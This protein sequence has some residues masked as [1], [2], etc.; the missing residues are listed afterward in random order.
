MPTPLDWWGALHNDK[1]V[2]VSSSPSIVSAV[3]AKQDRLN[4]RSSNI[5]SMK[6]PVA[7]QTFQP[8][9]L[10]DVKP[11]ELLASIGKMTTPPIANL[12]DISSTWASI[13][14]IWAFEP[15]SLSSGIPPL[16]LSQEARGIDFH[17]KA[18]LSDEMGVGFAHYLM[19]K[20]FNAP[21]PAD[22]SSVIN[23]QSYGL[24]PIGKARPDYVFFD[25]ISGAKY[26]VE[27]KGTQTSRAESV[28]QLQRGTEQVS[29]IQPTDGQT[30]TRFIVATCMQKLKTEIFFL[31]PPSDDSGGSNF[32]A[33]SH[34]E[35]K[36]ER[37]WSPEGRLF[38]QNVRSVAAA[39]MF[40][41]AGLDEE[42]LGMLP[43]VLRK[44][45]SPTRRDNA[46]LETVDTDLGQ[47]DGSL[48]S[49]SYG[50]GTEIGIFRGI[51]SQTRKYF[52]TRPHE[53]SS[54]LAAEREPPEFLSKNHDIF[55]G[56]G[57]IT[58]YKTDRNATRV[59]SIC[60]D[61]TMLEIRVRER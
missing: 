56:K 57:Y 6:T 53:S 40:T 35:K 45:F 8:D 52:T 2:V 1:R 25:E 7:V 33:G 5:P 21:S 23:D 15:R 30:L 47:F 43:D 31:D 55:K 36:G 58:T 26:V 61:G 59:Q 10:V 29:A 51:S 49:Q 34:D 19:S 39:K 54:W 22:V 17:Q 41:Y 46:L 11:I 50:A 12:A 14:Y 44:R 48:I 24:Y 37:I 38:R 32:G 4:S 60:R 18:L 9:L 28:R 3:I 16:R 13:R 20:Y 42:A 27:C